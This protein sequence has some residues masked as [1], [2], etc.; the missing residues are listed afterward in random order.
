MMRIKYIILCALLLPAVAGLLLTTAGCARYRDIPP[1]TVKEIRGP[2]FEGV[3]VTDLQ[4]AKPGSGM[5]T[6]GAAGATGEAT[7]GAGRKD[8]STAS[9]TGAAAGAQTVTGSK[10]TAPAAGSVS[11]AG[12]SPGAAGQKSTRATTGAASPAGESQTGS[13]V[14]AAGPSVE[15][16]SVMGSRTA[17]P[18]SPATPVGGAPSSGAAYPTVESRST[19]VNAD[20]RSGMKSSSAAR[21][22]TDPRSPIRESETVTV[23]P[24]SEPPPS[25]DYI[26]GPYDVL[27]INVSGKPEFSSIASS[28]ASSSTASNLG[29]IIQA[30]G[31][32]VDGSG[33]IQLPFVG[34]VH[35][36]GMTP[37]EIQNR[38]MDIYPKYFNNPWVIV[39]VKEYK[40]HPLYLLG[41]FRTSG[42][43]YMDRPLNLLQGIALGNGYDP[44]AD[45]SSARLIREKRTMPVDIYDLLTNGDQRQN[46]WLKPED[47]LYIPNNT[48]RQVFIFG[49]VK[50]PGPLPIPSGGLS[51]SQAIASA[52]LRDTGYDLNYVRIIRSYSATRGE[53][54]VID[55]EKIMRGDALSL[56]LRNGDIVYVP[57]SHLGTWNDALNE[58]LPSLQTISALLQ[59]FVNIKY[60][61]Q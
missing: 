2:G 54:M 25:P 46:V 18:A 31:C 24:L 10:T 52:E 28:G 15:A 43:F 13:G 55:F 49:A 4:Q 7:T 42:T 34:T 26:V 57:K 35:V 36:W 23:Q 44:T 32:R 38:L 45:L 11:P 30:T 19:V 16:I 29:A 5:S 14:R 41:Q 20:T 8:S 12:E 51:L 59:P 21:P 61:R 50:K 27:S 9:P 40:S 6:V 3:G 17:S 48:N 33:N 60:L 39:D 37:L 53:L 47:T 22:I 1:G 56:A 58:L